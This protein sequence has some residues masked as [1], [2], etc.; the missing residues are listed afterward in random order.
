VTRVLAGADFDAERT[1]ASPAALRALE[2]LIATLRV[3]GYANTPR[4]DVAPDAATAMSFALGHP[5]GYGDLDARHAEALLDAGAA[6]LVD[7][8]VAPRFMIYACGSVMVLVP[9]DDG[10]HPARVYFGQD[11]MWLADLATRL[12]VHGGWYADLGTGAGA[13][14]ALVAARHD[15]AV[16]TDLL[17]RTAAAA[18]ITAHLNRRHDGRPLADIVVADVGEGLRPGQFTLVT[19][20]PPWVPSQRVERAFA[21]GGP[22]GFDLPRRFVVSAAQLLAPGG[23]AITLVL[24]ATWDDGT[25]PAVAL[26]R[27]LQRLGFE[28]AIE[29]T[30]GWPELEGEMLARVPGLRSARHVALLVRR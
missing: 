3:A 16:G 10:G 30:P 8:A 18:S 7:G 15:H 14:M 17:P 2:D 4:A 22:S 13:V 27:G 12:D 20:N 6:D 21:D 9:R 24:D 11:S 23:V 25:R 1:R 28:T 19:A 29:P 5:V 26:A